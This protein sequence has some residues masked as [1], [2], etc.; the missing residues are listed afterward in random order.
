MIPAEILE[1][2]SIERVF[3][4]SDSRDRMILDVA[5][6]VHEDDWI[7]AGGIYAK[8]VREH[9]DRE[10]RDP[11]DKDSV[12]VIV[13]QL[14]HWCLNNNR[15]WLAARLLWPESVFDARPY[16]TRLIWQAWSDSTKIMEMG[17]ASASK[18]Y[19]SGVWLLLDWLR[20]PEYTC[21]RV[22][23]P[24]EDHLNQNL[25]THLVNM[26][27]NASIPLPGFTGDRWIGLDRKNQFGAITGV[28]IPLGKKR[29][30]RLQGTKAG[31]KK[32][33]KAHPVFGTLGRL[34]VFIDESEKVPEGIW[35]DID[36]VMANVAGLETFKIGC[37]YNPEDQNGKSAER[38]EPPAGWEKG[39]DLDTSVRWTSKRGWTVIRLDGMKGENVIEGYTLFPGLQT[40]EGIETLITNAG[41]Y[42][43]PG[44]Y[45]MARAAF[46][47]S[48]KAMVVITQ[49]TLEN[50]KGDFVFLT[51]PTPCA[52]VDL[53][54]EGGDAAEFALGEFGQ[55]IGF[56]EPPNVMNPEGKYT[57]FR[58][59]SGHQ[60]VR[61]ALQVKQVFKLPKGDTV[62]MANQV[63]DLCQKSG[64]QGGWLCVDRTGN[65]QGVY[66]TLK[67]FWSADVIGVNGFEGATE[68]KILEE[69]E[70]T[71][72][73][74]YD[75]AN[76]ELWFAT[77]KFMEFC[78]VKLSPII[79]FTVLGAQLTGRNYWTGKLN[80]VESKKEYKLR[81][82]GKSPDAADAVTLIV[83]AAR[84]A[85]GTVPSMRLD[86][87]D[88]G[89]LGLQQPQQPGSSRCGV[90]DRLDN[91][92]D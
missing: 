35:L 24:S 61:P 84:V 49:A 2:Y 92:I 53:A 70:K 81:H 5:Q 55:A 80:R 6:F 8:W 23:G 7:G 59:S 15:Y 66:D 48:I 46:P 33:K 12:Q 86:K 76:S 29:A 32:R 69:D 17:S 85:S 1:K 3:E 77:K 88:V 73:Q 54:L 67:N 39:F 28:V 57:A 34:R 82:G 60:I 58:D 47:P 37:A 56:R 38:S 41:G 71:A 11:Q 10:Y 64:V 26:H 65:G 43:S 4:I 18:S 83:H 27:Q 44:Y 25:F 75:R 72:K 51:K 31:N 20:D 89:L 22:I 13:T 19:S 52:G 74:D 78:I 90:T 87:G 9:K 63:R 14:V 50:S 42:E 91:S 79:D 45:T 40:R 36:N 30:G 16:F 62:A 68:K 21:V